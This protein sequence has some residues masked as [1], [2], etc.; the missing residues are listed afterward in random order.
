MLYDKV[1]RKNLE[2]E[3]D[4]QLS[5]LHAVTDEFFSFI[6]LL[7][8]RQVPLS[9][10]AL[11]F[12]LKGWQVSPRAGGQVSPPGGSAGAGYHVVRL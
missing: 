1:T 7:L 3:T 9:Q 12:I 6:I 11:R 2:G 4:S 10:D 5:P 8:S